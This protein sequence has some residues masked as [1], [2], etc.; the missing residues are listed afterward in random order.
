MTSDTNWKKWRRQLMNFLD[1]LDQNSQISSA[2]VAQSRSKINGFLAASAG[3][4]RVVNAGLLNAGKSTLFNA[5]CGQ[6]ELF[7]MA[8]ARRTVKRQAEKL[9]DFVLVDT[10][11]LDATEEDE[12]EAFEVYRHS[13]VILFA[14]SAIK[15][16]FEAMEIAF[17][18]QLRDL[19]P[20]RQLR[21]KSIIPVITKSANI[22]GDIDKVVNKIRQQW[23]QAMGVTPEVI[24]AVRAKTHL[25]GL[26]EDKEL[27]CQHSQVPALIDHIQTVIAD[28]S[29]HQ[30][31]LFRRRIN[32]EI[33]GLV[34]LLD[35]AITRQQ[36]KRDKARKQVEKQISLINAD[37][38]DFADR[39]RQAYRQI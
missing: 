2:S 25:K 36:E 14:H 37:V 1:R 11:G 9:C 30:K 12:K 28:V 19:Y 4:P 17:L 18:K 6:Q 20:D 21:K 39:H 32:D 8:G 13:Q 22:S 33:D 15:G 16:E 29:D 3:K 27:L 24:Y 5:I 23:Q 26:A 35:R 10:P 7:A 31:A 34:K 38:K